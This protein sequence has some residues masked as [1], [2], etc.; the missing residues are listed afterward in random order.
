MI[1]LFTGFSSGEKYST[2]ADE[3]VPSP[4]NRVGLA[5]FEHHYPKML[6]G[7]MQQRTAIAR[8]F[9]ELKARL[10]EEIRVEALKAVV[11]A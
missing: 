1:A 9:S 2:P 11:T 10:T 6:S 7:G 3:R 8:E 4:A 5:G